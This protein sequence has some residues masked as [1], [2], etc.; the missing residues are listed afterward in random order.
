MATTR[1]YR[2]VKGKL[3]RQPEITDW[4]EDRIRSFLEFAAF[5]MKEGTLRNGG[6]GIV[7]DVTDDRIASAWE[8]PDEHWQEFLNRLETKDTLATEKVKR[9]NA[10]RTRLMNFIRVVCSWL[11][12]NPQAITIPIEQI[13]RSNPRFSWALDTFVLQ[14]TPTG[15]MLMP[16]DSPETTSDTAQNVN[17]L[18]S[19]SKLPQVRYQ[20][21]VA[22]VTALLEELVSSIDRNQIKSMSPDKKLGLVLKMIEVLGKNYKDAPGKTSVFNTLVVGK[23]GRED[24]ERMLLEQVEPM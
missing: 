17:P 18:Q 11:K 10:F 13:M 21:S 16:N 4:S 24:L 15:M 19:D 9:L 8:N 6:T 5:F 14:E 3:P 22:K 1:S 7:Y 2:N 20:N 12:K 23:S